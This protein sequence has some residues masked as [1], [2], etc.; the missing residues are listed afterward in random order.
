[1]YILKLN[2]KK[3]LEKCASENLAIAKMLQKIWP[4]QKCF[5]K[6]GHCKNAS[7]N[8][9]FFFYSQKKSNHKYLHIKSLISTVRFL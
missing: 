9:G 1:M 6:F 8:L 3:A 7:K 5:K 2:E 4:L